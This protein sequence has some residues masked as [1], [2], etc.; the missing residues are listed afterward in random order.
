MGIWAGAFGILGC[1]CFRRRRLLVRIGRHLF[2]LLL[3]LLL[4]LLLLLPPKCRYSDSQDI[5]PH[6]N[7][8][9]FYCFNLPSRE[10]RSYE[11]HLIGFQKADFLRI[12]QI[13]FGSKMMAGSDENSAFLFNERAF[14]DGRAKN[15]CGLNVAYK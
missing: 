13:F 11:T 9:R 3:L 8:I 5:P 4:H 2:L 15:Y 12:C 7:P 1:R 10:W 14:Y 6:E